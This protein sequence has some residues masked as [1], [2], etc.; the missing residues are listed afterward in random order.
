MSMTSPQL[1]RDGTQ[2]PRLLKF[3]QPPRGRTIKDLLAEITPSEAALLDAIWHVNDRHYKHAR[4]LPMARATRIV[5]RREPWP[6]SLA[7]RAWKVH[8][9][10]LYFH[11]VLDHP[12][13]PW[14]DESIGRPPISPSLGELRL[15]VSQL[16]VSRRRR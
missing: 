16:R 4:F 9:E 5:G 13:P 2:H 15:I 11:G 14:L 8:K 10:L 6:A 7:V 3:S 12:E 1:S